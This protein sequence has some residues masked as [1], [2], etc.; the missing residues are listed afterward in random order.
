L[1]RAL[2]EQSGGATGIRDLGLLESS[3]AQ[4]RATFGGADLHPTVISKAAALG[5]S[6]ALNHAF[7][8]GNKRIAHAAMEV[9]LVLNGYELH[10]SIDEQEALMLNLAA[11]KIPREQL[12]SWLERH[13]MQAPKDTST[14]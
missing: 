6:L 13:V 9:F 3:L 5:Y 14:A 12:A 7:V 10:A 1:R 4:P 11:G 8:D 2:L